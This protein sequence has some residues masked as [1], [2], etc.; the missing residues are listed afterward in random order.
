[1]FWPVYLIIFIATEKYIVPVYDIYCPIDDYIPFCE[2]FVV[3]Y[4]LWYGLL[5]FVSLY[6]LFYDIPTFKKFYRFLIFSSILS[7]TIFI[8]FPS[9]QNL[10]PDTF[11]RDNIFVSV[12]RDGIYAA[13]TNTNVCP[14]L[15]VVFGMGMLFSLWNSKHFSSVGWRITSIITTILVCMSTVFLKQH[16]VIDI[17]V[18]VILSVALLPFVFLKSKPYC[19][20]FKKE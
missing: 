8:V 4:F 7:F 13:D 12:M 11:A 15:H 6:G 5:A 19:K 18:G 1:M 17:G 20:F 9:E 2:F 14:S 10:R 16:S 3:P